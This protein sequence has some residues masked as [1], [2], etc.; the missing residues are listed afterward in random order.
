MTR[1][2]QGGEFFLEPHLLKG[3]LGEKIERVK[4]ILN[5]MGASRIQAREEEIR[6]RERERGRS[7]NT[8]RE[9]RRRKRKQKQRERKLLTIYP[10]IKETG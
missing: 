1:Q 4:H 3:T 2:V 9:R 10:P 8:F 5:G 6:K 7:K